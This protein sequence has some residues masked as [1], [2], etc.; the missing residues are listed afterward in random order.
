MSFVSPVRAVDFAILRLGQKRL[1]RHL[2]RGKQVQTSVTSLIP[3][4]FHIGKD[5]KAQKCEEE[6]SLSTTSSLALHVYM[7]SHSSIELR[8]PKEER[9]GGEGPQGQR[10]PELCSG[11]RPGGHRATSSERLPPRAQ[12]LAQEKEK[13]EREEKR[14]RK[15]EEK[16]LL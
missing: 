9:R 6:A 2:A 11:P 10:L 4:N 16:E 15:E 12:R 7:S 5:E 1:V 14:K 3:E 8:R 13:G